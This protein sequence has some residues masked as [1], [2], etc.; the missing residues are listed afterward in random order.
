MPRRMARR[1]GA[2]DALTRP[3]I[4][5]LLPFA[6]LWLTD[7]VT[8]S[9]LPDEPALLPALM[10]YFPHAAARA[11]RRASRTPPAAARPGRDHRRQRGGEPA[12][13]RRAGPA[14]HG[15]RAGRR[16]PRRLL[17]AEAFGLEAACDVDRC[18]ARAGRDAACRAAGAAPPAGSR[19]AGPARRA[20]ATAGGGAGG[21]AARH[22]G[23]LAAAA[24]VMST[25]AAGLPA[26]AGLLAAAAPRLAAAPAVVR[27]A[28][29]AGVDA[30]AAATAWGSIEAR[31]ALDALR[32][33]IAAA[34]APGPFGPR[35]R[36]ALA[37]EVGTAQARLAARLLRGETP[38]DARSDTVAA[39]VRDAAGARDLAAVTVAVRAVA[40]LG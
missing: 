4:A 31:F 6:K 5:A 28:G 10:A 29:A 39:L 12:G 16:L 14:D 23:A 36:A 30:T 9:T 37:E 34:P 38:D 8:E 17:A 33:A 32:A 1:I 26:E 3:E 21:A 20:G 13:L 25:P 40:M 19:G 7:A 18:R 35:A 11:L 15:G 24:A 2:G 27:L 22:R